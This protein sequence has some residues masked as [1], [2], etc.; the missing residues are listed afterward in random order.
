[1]LDRLV[2]EGVVFDGAYH[3]GAWAGPVCTP[4]RHMIM[5]GRTILHIQGKGSGKPF[6]C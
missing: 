5:S 3:M 1:M 4:S 2:A 6:H